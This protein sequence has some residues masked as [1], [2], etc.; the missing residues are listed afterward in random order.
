MLKAEYTTRGPVPHEVISAVPME[1]G[2]PQD[3]GVL[4]ELMASPINPSDVL[5]LTGEYGRLP[6]L[7]AIGGSEGVGRVTEVGSEVSNVKVGDV[8]LLP[9]GS[10]T[11]RTH[12]LLRAEGLVVLP[13]DADPLQLAMMTVNPPTAS[14]LLASFVDLSEGDWL[15]QN[16]ANSAVGS[17]LIQLAARRG[18]RTVNIV[19]RES[20]VASVLDIGGDVC[21]VDG[22]GLRKRVKEATNDAPIALGIDAVAGESTGRIAATLAKEA[23]LVNYGMMSGQPCVLPPRFLVFGG[24]SVRGF[25]L[26]EWFQTATAAERSAL[27]AEIGGLVASGSL[28]APVAATFPIRQVS[29]AVRLAAEGNR[30]G[31]VLLVSE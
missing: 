6:P 7:P 31:K 26:A 13:G 3:T 21:V 2:P 24:I 11:W 14:L 5:M 27:F 30:S 16:A 12:M 19:R 1:V 18:I 17:Y 4:V 28:M 29:D 8:V 9:P 10:G 23:V 15:I 25:W 22:P 20:A